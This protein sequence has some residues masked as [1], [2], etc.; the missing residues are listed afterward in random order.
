MGTSPLPYVEENTGSWGSK[1]VVYKI[2]ANEISD[3]LPE[4]V[5]NPESFP[6]GQFHEEGSAGGSHF[7]L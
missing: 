4:L 1:E 2:D 7:L 5:L 6:S 3:V